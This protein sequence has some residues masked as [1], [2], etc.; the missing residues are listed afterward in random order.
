[1]E[2]LSGTKYVPHKASLEEK[3]RVFEGVADILIEL[4][5]FP[6]GNACSFVIDDEGTCVPG[7]IASVRSKTLAPF[8]PF[9]SAR[10]YYEYIVE[11]HMNLIMEGKLCPNFAVEALL[12]YSILRDNICKILLLSK[13]IGG[14]AAES[15]YLTHIDPKGDHL[16][17]NSDGYITGIID[18]QGARCVPFTEAFGPSLLTADLHAMYEGTSGITED[19]VLLSNVLLKKGAPHI[20]HMMTRNSMSRRLHF[21]L[22]SA[23]TE[24]EIWDLIRGLLSAFE[25][26]YND[27]LEEWRRNALVQ[28]ANDVR[29]KMLTEGVSK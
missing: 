15:F 8:G 21:G 14:G 2:G 23:V 25:I 27:D 26:Y 13:D 10:H 11:A 16:L 28:Y 17:L 1:M 20:A 29:V 7:K 4:H 19:D 12:T 6:V 9:D 22:G 3:K 18:W 24:A 5:K